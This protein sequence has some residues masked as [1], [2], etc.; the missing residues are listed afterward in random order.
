MSLRV[1]T[2]FIVLALIFNLCVVLSP[3]LSIVLL[4]SVE[5]SAIDVLVIN[6]GN[7]LR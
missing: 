7:V 5:L 4:L 6:S 3:C 2:T 1:F